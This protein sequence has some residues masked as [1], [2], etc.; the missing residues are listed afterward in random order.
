MSTPK[1][2]SPTITLFQLRS[3]YHAGLEKPMRVYLI[4]LKS[5]AYS[6]WVNPNVIDYISEQHD[7]SSVMGGVC[8]VWSIIHRNILICD[9]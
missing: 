2:G 9:Y 8:K 1:A 3:N 4:Y 5:K 6:L 7:S